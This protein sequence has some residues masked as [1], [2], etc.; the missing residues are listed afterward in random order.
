VAGDLQE[1]TRKRLMAMPR[2]RRPE[3]W[4]EWFGCSREGR[5]QRTGAERQDADEE[6]GWRTGHWL[7]QWHREV[8]D[9]W[10]RRLQ[11]RGL[12]TATQWQRMVS[13]LQD[14]GWAAIAGCQEVWRAACRLR[15]DEDEERAAERLAMERRARDARWRAATAAGRASK[16]EIAARLKESVRVMRAEVER[17]KPERGRGWAAHWSARAVLQ[18]GAKTAFIRRWAESLRLLEERRAREKVAG[19]ATLPDVAVVEAEAMVVCRGPRG[20]RERAG[21]RGKAMIEAGG[22]R[23]E[24]GHSSG[25]SVPRGGRIPGD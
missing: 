3:G 23:R 24:W 12:A 18:W 1:K 20:I 15:A 10:W 19:E 2:A 9:D 7:G 4:E 5:W 14:L 13:L 6:T 8:L 25:R 21:D 17:S 22:K 16:R 11:E